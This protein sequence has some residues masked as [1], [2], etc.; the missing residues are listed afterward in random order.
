MRQLDHPNIVRL[1]EVF[2]DE[3]RFYL[4]TELCQG[5]ELFEEITKRA[6]FNEQDAASIIKQILSAI[7]YCHSKSIVHRDLKPENILLEDKKDDGDFQI[8]V[9]DFGASMRFDPSKKMNQVFGTAYYIAPE[10]LK[11]E[12]NEKCDVWSVGVILYILLS[13]KP[14]FGGENDKEILDNVRTGI[15]SMSGNEWTS[16][17]SEA[18]NLV[19]QML[20]FDPIQRISAEEALNH[21]WIKKKFNQTVDLEATYNALNNLRSF[22]VNDS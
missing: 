13:G 20:T 14:P 8:K 15:F 4:V 18:K 5:G 16:V 9:I 11:L 12:Y 10:I 7:A 21:L 22:R 1:Y 3:K 17:S 2:H 6:N 19:K